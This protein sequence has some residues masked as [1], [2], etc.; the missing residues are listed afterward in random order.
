MGTAA[1]VVGLMV[2]LGAQ[3][4]SPAPSSSS[5][6]AAHKIIF[7]AS[8]ESL[9]D[10]VGQGVSLS[11]SVIE[12]D[13]RMLNAPTRGLP[14]PGTDLHPADAIAGAAIPDKVIVVPQARAEQCK[15]TGART[16][17]KDG[18][19]VGITF[20]TPVVNGDTATVQAFVRISRPPT[21]AELAQIQARRPASVERF[22]Q[23]I[24]GATM[25]R[26]SLALKNGV[27]TVVNRQIIGQS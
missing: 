15:G 1:C 26:M 11:R 7:R 20:D 14:A 6:S 24:G 8:V 19:W 5:S 27:W 21:E 13:P 12:V 16:C 9:S 23:E 18:L 22:A 4:P 17:R 25:F 10:W 3:T 2:C